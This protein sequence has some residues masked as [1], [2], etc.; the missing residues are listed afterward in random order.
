[1]VHLESRYGEIVSET[2]LTPTVAANKVL[3]P[4]GPLFPVVPRRNPK[5]KRASNPR[6]IAPPASVQVPQSQ[7]PPKESLLKATAPSQSKWTLPIDTVLS[8]MPFRV[9]PV[10][11]ETP[12][13]AV[14]SKRAEGADPDDSA[15]RQTA[16]FILQALWRLKGVTPSRPVSNALGQASEWLPATAQL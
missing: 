5:T 3:Y 14:T 11:A 9:S 1:M 13:E 8:C 6:R 10:K 15:A 12:A 7:S 4:R 16:I 2:L